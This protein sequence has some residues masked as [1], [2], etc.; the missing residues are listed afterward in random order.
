[1]ILSMDLQMMQFRLTGLYLS[2][3]RLVLSTIKFFAHSKNFPSLGV[4]FFNC[5]TRTE[6][7]STNGQTLAEPTTPDPV[8]LNLF[9]VLNSFTARSS[10]AVGFG[11]SGI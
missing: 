3:Q 4:V 10:F 6:T 7:S 2:D 1:M 11:V 5:G 8:A 9:V